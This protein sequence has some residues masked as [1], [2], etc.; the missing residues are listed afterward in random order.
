MFVD[1][2]KIYVKGGDGGNGI[3]AFRREKYVPMGGPAGG[4]GGRG[5]HVIFQADEGLRTLMDFKYKKHF[6]APRGNHGGGKNM[7]GANGEDL[8]VK[9]PPGTLVKDL[10]TGDILA[11][12]VA[13]GQQQIVA[14]GG[15]GGRGNA[16]FAN[17]INKAPSISENGAPGEERWLL[18]ELKV[19][20][21]V[22]LVG[23]PNAGKSTLISRISAARPKIADYPFTTLTPNL[24]VVRTRD[25][26]S[27]VVADIPGLIEGAHAGAGLGH[28]FLRHVERTRVLLFVLDAAQT[29]GRDVLADYEVLRRELNQYQ[30]KLADQPYLIVAN[31]M[32]LPE[33]RQNLEGLSKRFGEKLLPISAATG[34]GIDF[35]IERTRALLAEANQESEP[36]YTETPVTRRFQTDEAFKIDIINGVYEVSGKR[37]ERLVSMTNFNSDESLQRFQ[38][39]VKHMGLE[40]A[41]KAKG[42]Q[43]GDTV[44]INELVLEYS[45]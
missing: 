6:K 14:C 11:D 42:I 21:D 35:L 33:A 18:L 24:G 32:D 3:I 40:E 28:D 20:A 37:I 39:T 36:V 1:Q 44:K 4:D 7:H 9:V 19:L 26:E 30:S 29:E 10:D 2:A 43:P 25:G 23:F 12:L 45:E 15:R 5:G 41:L 16:R 27:F 8:L 38:Q 34:E 22:G 17:P 13:H 31:K